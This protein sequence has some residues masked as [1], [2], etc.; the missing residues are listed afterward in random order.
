VSDRKLGVDGNS[1]GVIDYYVADV[2]TANDFYPFGSL[3]PGRKWQGGSYRYGF[4]G[5]E[6][7]DELKGEGNSINY[8]FRVY[9]PRIGRFL[10]IDPL[11]EKYPFYSPYHFSSNQPI[12][13]PELE[14]LESEFDLN[15]PKSTG[16]VDANHWKQDPTHKNPN[17]M[18]WKDVNGNSLY[19]DK[20]QFD[21]DGKP[22]PG[23]K[24]KDHFHFEDAG[25]SRYNAAGNVA[26]TKGASET[27]LSPGTQT[28]IKVKASVATAEING[29]SATTTKTTP[30]PKTTT[31]KVNGTLKSVFVVADIVSSVTGIVSG[32]PDALINQFGNAQVGQLKAGTLDFYEMG[33]Y[34]GG[35]DVFANYYMITNEVTKSWTE[36][37][38][39]FK[40]ITRY[41]Q[42]YEGKQKVNGKY[43]GQGE[44]GPRFNQTQTYKDGKLI[45]KGQLNNPNNSM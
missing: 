20:A 25:G 36:N 17:G 3:M 5:Q 21:A 28:S 42:H 6:K 12:H 40:T 26:K 1:D 15:L 24:G 22:L 14:G 39:N 18:K 27:H 44:V 2:L 29:V 34:N 41:V 4:Q 30:T 23:W 43:I 16:D 32:N 8:A 9:D 11:T 37:G 35:V 7:D 33:P 10:S 45:D 38:T 31:Q 19:F 13:A